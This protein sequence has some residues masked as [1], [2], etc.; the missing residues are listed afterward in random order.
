MA[1]NNYTLRIDDSISVT[2]MEYFSIP[3]N[4]EISDY[5]LKGLAYD[6]LAINPFQTEICI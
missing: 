3:T 4:S 5:Q 1:S 2:I 6:T